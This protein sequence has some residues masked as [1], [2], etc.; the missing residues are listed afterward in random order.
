MLSRESRT[1]AFGNV[2]VEYI[3]RTFVL[4]DLERRLKSVYCREPGYVLLLAASCSSSHLFSVLED[5][6]DGDK[7]CYCGAVA[8]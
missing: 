6:P 4:T 1:E 7:R 8:S 5:R 3:R 2:W